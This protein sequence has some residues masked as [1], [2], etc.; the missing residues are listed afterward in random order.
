M[1]EIAN[2]LPVWLPGYWVGVT[3]LRLLI[4]IAVF[5][6][7]GR[8]AKREGSAV[9]RSVWISSAVLS[10]W[11]V[12]AIYLGSRNAFR[13]HEDVVL[14]PPIAGGALVPILVGWLA[15]QY[16]EPFRRLI[17]R[18]PQHWLIALQVY[19]VTGGG[20]W[21]DSSIA[22]PLRWHLVRKSGQR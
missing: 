5:Y 22:T 6:W 14:P 11:V 19:R 20:I 15:F 9:G 12:A 21:V 4:M 17:F 10:L 16:W 18:I 8:A 13:I 7:F 2:N 1:N 3:V